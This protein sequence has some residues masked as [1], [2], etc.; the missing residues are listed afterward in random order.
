MLDVGVE[1]ALE[2]LG[3][4]SRVLAYVERD[5]ARRKDFKTAAPDR[6]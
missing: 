3:I 1:F 2:Y 4:R 5:A 6:E